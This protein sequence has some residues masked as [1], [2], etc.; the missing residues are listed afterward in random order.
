MNRPTCM[1]N[2][3]DVRPALEV[4]GLIDSEN[5][6]DQSTSQSVRPGERAQVLNQDPRDLDLS[7]A[8]FFLHDL[9]V[10]D[11]VKH[12]IEMDRLG[13]PFLPLSLTIGGDSTELGAEATLI[14]F[15]SDRLIG[16]SL[17][18]SSAHAT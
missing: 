14:S 6:L 11:F 18:G 3:R 9:A 12:V 16:L 8:H 1:R 17:S 10:N 5:E 7:R 13:D 15:S 2:E 4:F